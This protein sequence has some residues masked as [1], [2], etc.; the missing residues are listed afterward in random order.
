MSNKRR[1]VVTFGHLPISVGGKQS[2]G[3][4][5]VIWSLANNINQVSNHNIKNIIVAT[6]VHVQNKTIDQTDVV[7]WNRNLLIVYGLSHP[8]L[9]VYYVYK[10]IKLSIKYGFPIFNMFAKMLFYHRS[11]Y[12]I[13]PDFIHL[14]D[15]TS[16]VFFEIWR[17]RNFKIFATIHGI[18]GQD[19]LKSG[20]KNC[21]K[22][23]TNLSQL[24]LKF[25]VFV[26]SSLI[27]D[28]VNVY[29]KPVWK[30]EVIT[31]AYDNKQ[32]YLNKN[33][34]TKKI[35]T[36]KPTFVTVGS[37]SLLK[38]QS[39]VLEALAKMND[40]YHYICIGRGSSEQINILLTYAHAHNISFEYAGYLDPGK[41][42]EK[43]SVVDFM[44]APSSSEGFGLVFLE[45][46]ACG[47]PVIIPKTLPIAKENNILNPT[48][49]I[50]MEDE[51]SKSI[52]KVL[53]TLGT[54]TFSKDFV[55]KTVLNYS[56]EYAAEKYIHLISQ[57]Q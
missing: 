46:I 33:I 42:R 50:L 5:N 3:L 20:Y 32:F 36:D 47:V 2:S 11:I 1:I 26:S 28:W 39:R 53:S 14:H 30:K 45:S 55:A 9:L 6:D 51:S 57:Y 37:I 13:K 27:N 19:N 7:G 43:L 44:I 12:Y 15:C 22:M 18:S 25:V 48:N 10:T 8:W 56:W 17:I 29:G 38:G 49:S 4:A 52:L 31:N 35:N 23:E 16:V 21:R 54:Y 41:I 34:K 40:N 24:P